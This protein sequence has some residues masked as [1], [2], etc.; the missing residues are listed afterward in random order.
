[1]NSEVKRAR[2]IGL[3]YLLVILLAGFSQGYVRASLFVPGDAAATAN[4]IANSEALF[5]LGFATDLTAFLIDLAISILLYLLLKPV[6][7]TLSLL[8][9]AFRLLAH[10][11]IGS[12]NLLNHYL[13]LEVLGG[14]GMAASFDAGQSQELVLLLMNA[15]R[16]GYLIAGAFF[17]IHCLLLGIL[18]H[19]SKQ[20]PGL[21]GILMGIAALGYLMESFGNFLFP[22]NEG[23]LALLVGISAAVGEVSLT[24]YLLVKGVRKP[25]GMPM[26]AA[27]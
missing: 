20:F 8:A 9:A 13:V 19:R 11:A 16:D 27:A 26:Q 17:G 23:W 6:D 24:F 15:H 22:G 21:L 3:L 12:L 14:G 4:N 2:T 10:P 5:R 7:H 1:M 18:L 25:P